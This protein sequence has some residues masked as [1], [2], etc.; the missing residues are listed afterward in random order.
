MEV[1]CRAAGLAIR[2]RFLAVE[3][4]MKPVS[5]NP[6]TDADVHAEPAQRVDKS[7]GVLNCGF[8]RIGETRKGR[9]ANAKEYGSRDGKHDQQCVV[10]HGAPW[11]AGSVLILCAGRF[12]ESPPAHQRQ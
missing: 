1:V 7:D 6:D 5:N 9:S 8:S 11:E 3:S 4:P 10:S 12:L 2:C